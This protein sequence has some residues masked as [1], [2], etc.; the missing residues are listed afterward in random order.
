MIL[1]PRICTYAYNLKIVG[2]GQV[3]EN[4]KGQNGKD[5][6]TTNGS[7]GSVGYFLVTLRGDF[8]LGF[9]RPH[10]GLAILVDRD[11]T[12]AFKA[13]R[14]GSIGKVL[15]VLGSRKAGERGFDDKGS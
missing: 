15:V 5:S 13:S 6:H 7:V 10:V 9:N 11:T 2:I 12:F 8:D 1:Y 3:G 14:Q 4:A